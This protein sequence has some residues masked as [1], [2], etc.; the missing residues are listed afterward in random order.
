MPVKLIHCVKSPYS[1]LFSSAFSPHFPR[2][3]PHSDWRRRDTEYL[4][5]F[6]PNA[7]KI[8]ARITPNTDYFY[9]VINSL[10]FVWYQKAKFGEDLTSLQQLLKIAEINFLFSK[11]FSTFCRVLVLSQWKQLKQPLKQEKL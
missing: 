10:K 7:G 3:F 8:R 5:V 9:A 1:N 6:S 2:I 11:F 4:S